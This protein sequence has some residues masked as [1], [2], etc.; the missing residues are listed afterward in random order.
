MDKFLPKAP[1]CT[2]TQAAVL[3]DSSLNMLV[4][5][6]C[7]LSMVEDGG[8]KAMISTFHPNYKLPSRT[9][10]TKKVVQVGRHQRGDV[11]SPARDWQRG[12]HNRGLYGGDALPSELLENGVLLPDNNAL[13]R[14]T[15]SCKYCRMDWGNCQIQHSAAEIQG[16][17]PQQWH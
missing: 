13:G 2:A 16:H 9:F 5:D 11:E 10:L 12:A 3:S 8:F 7:L 15:H 4:T 6:M 14:E 1:V 17:R